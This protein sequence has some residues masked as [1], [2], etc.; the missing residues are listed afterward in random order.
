MERLIHD[1]NG[2]ALGDNLTRSNFPLLGLAEFSTGLFARFEL[3]E[4]LDEGPPVMA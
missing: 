1:G 4:R 3:S 2:G